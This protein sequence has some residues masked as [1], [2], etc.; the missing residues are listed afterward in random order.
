[1]GAINDP[2]S[3]LSL[4]N[5]ADHGD[6]RE[7]ALWP[8]VSTS[9]TRYEAFWRTLIVLLTNRIDPA[10]MGAAL[11]RLRTDIPE[12]YELLAMHNYSLFCYAAIARQAIDEDRRRLQASEYPQP[13]RVFSAFQICSDRSKNLQNLANILLHEVGIDW[14]FSKHPESVYQTVCAYRNAFAHDPV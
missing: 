2:F 14:K 7:K 11:M 1:M 8:T 3:E 12:Q 5:L 13:E 10:I 6:A 4:F 9:L